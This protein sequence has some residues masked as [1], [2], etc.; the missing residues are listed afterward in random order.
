[1][2]IFN[3]FSMTNDNVEAET[4]LS[5][6]NA[7][8]AAILAHCQATGEKPEDINGES[9]DSMGN[10]LIVYSIY[11]VLCGDYVAIPKKD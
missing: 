10:P 6:P 11:G 2:Q 8:A 5:A 7:R 3:I 9:L 4:V 1:M